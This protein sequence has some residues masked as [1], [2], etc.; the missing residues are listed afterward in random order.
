MSQQTFYQSIETEGITK[1]RS[2]SEGTTLLPNST[3]QV[4]RILELADA[5]NLRA[6]APG[7]RRDPRSC[8]VLSLAQMNTHIAINELDHIVT[9]H[10]GM[11]L[12]NLDRHLKTAGF[13]RRAAPM[14]LNLSVSEWIATGLIGAETSEVE[15]LS[16]CLLGLVAV[17]SDGSKMR[18]RPA[19]RKAMGPELWPLFVGTRSKYAVVTEA[20]FAIRFYQNLIRKDFVFETRSDA[21]Q[22][23]AWLRA[24]GLRGSYFLVDASGPGSKLV[25]YL[26]EDGPF[27]HAN[28]AILS[29][30]IKQFNGKA[31]AI[32]SSVIAPARQ[33]TVDAPYLSEILKHADPKGILG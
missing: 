16:A 23:K 27:C 13:M 5:Y 14:Q 8:F 33:N 20:T 1:T 24:S 3:E 31:S 30:V 9:V 19:P 29:E 22:A 17:R 21:G 26:D 11:S 32:G 15:P 2:L 7:S 18:C 12:R 28:K 25:V 10:G 4:C 6:C